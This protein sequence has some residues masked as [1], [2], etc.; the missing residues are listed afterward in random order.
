MADKRLKDF[1]DKLSNI[2]PEIMKAFFRRQSDEITKGKITMPQFFILEYLKRQGESKMSDLAKVMNVT[3]AATTGIIDRI[4]KYGY[5]KRV[6]D[7][8]D[9]RVIRIKIMR[10]GAKVVNKILEQR[11]KMILNVFGKLSEKDREN[12]LSI[13]LNIRNILI[14][15]KRRK[16]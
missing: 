1:A 3:T 5:I 11:R 2:L 9:R 4:I 13:L 16:K 8:K 7:E 15:E 6:Y 14:N 12:Y 10:K